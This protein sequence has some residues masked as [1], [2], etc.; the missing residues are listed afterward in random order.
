MT[1]KRAPTDMRKG[2]GG[3][4]R[5]APQDLDFDSQNPRLVEYFEGEKPTQ[6]GLLR[7]LWE[8]MAVDEVAMSIAASGYFDYEPLFVAEEKGRLVVIEG[9]RRLAAVKLL[10]DNDL[11]QELHATDLP[12]ISPARARELSSLPVIRTN[13]KST[14]LYFGFKH[15]NG[16]AKWDSYAKAHYI[17]QLH[18]EYH[19]PLQD[20][21]SQIGD[22]HRTVQRLFRGFMVIEQA[23][24]AKVFRRENR[25]NPHFSFSHLYTGLDYDGI[26]AFISLRDESTESDEPVPKTKVKELGELCT[27]LYGDKELDIAP[28]VERQNPHLRQLDE[29]LRSKEATDSL[30]AKLS[31]AVALEVSYG[32]ERVFHSA[33]IQAKEAL[34][35]ARGTL[36]TGF[37]GEEELCAWQ[38]QLLIWRRISPRRWNARVHRESDGEAV[39]M[40][41]MS[42]LKTV[43]KPH[44][45]NK[46]TYCRFCRD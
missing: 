6:D 43:P 30:R 29:V 17:G 24:K 9:N 34:Q 42:D 26:A 2:E 44:V 45:A 12:E 32:D 46:S 8:Q 25:Y 23:E 22:K 31:L 1:A 11:R 13:R 36:S 21:A 10:L 7:M 20:I 41:I 37:N 33:L 3:Y 35:K 19:V 14:W 27:W 28:Q 16:P 18:R 38:M 5:V 15:F 4:D 39:R 40:R